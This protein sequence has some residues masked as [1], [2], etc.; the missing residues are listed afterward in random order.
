M[1]EEDRLDGARRYLADLTDSVKALQAD[2]AAGA[3]RANGIAQ[4][5]EEGIA[6]WW[7]KGAPKEDRQA[8]FTLSI[9]ANALR[10]LGAELS[11]ALTSADR[12]DYLIRELFLHKEEEA[13]GKEGEP[14]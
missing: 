4:G 6:R 5:I 10:R 1:A 13:E 14:V 9:I 2:I 8:D 3:D 12:A 11:V 7:G